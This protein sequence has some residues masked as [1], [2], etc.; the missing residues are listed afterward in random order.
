[1]GLCALK[2]DLLAVKAEREVLIGSNAEPE[3]RSSNLRT[4]EPY[5]VDSNLTK[6]PLAHGISTSRSMNFEL[7]FGVCLHK[8][9]IMLC[10]SAKQ[11]IGRL[12]SSTEY[13]IFKFS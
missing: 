10:F 11:L 1:M 13:L 2:S 8:T 9:K 4:L 7:G 12:R 5:R 6:V 3:I